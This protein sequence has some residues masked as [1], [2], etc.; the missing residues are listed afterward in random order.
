MEV[1]RLGRIGAVAASLCHSHSN[2]RTKPCLRPTPQLTAMPD[3]YL[4][5]WTRPGIEC[6]SSWTPVIIC[7]CWATTS[8][9]KALFFKNPK[10]MRTHTPFAIVCK[11]NKTETRHNRK[12]HTGRE[13]KTTKKVLIVA[14]QKQIRLG[15][16]RLWVPSLASF[17]GL[18]I[19]HWLPWAVV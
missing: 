11:T 10:T 12:I 19:R 8:W 9:A 16:M 6:G 2:T 5:H 7:F 15:T 14:Q 18:R 13:K 1:P 17:G 3:P 4:T